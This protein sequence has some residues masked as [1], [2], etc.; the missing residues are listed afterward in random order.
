M[1]DEAPI[2]PARNVELSASGRIPDLTNSCRSPAQLNQNAW[3]YIVGA[4]RPRRPCA[5][6]AC[7]STRSHVPPARVLRNVAEVDPSAELFGLQIAAAG[8]DR[9]LSARLRYF[10]SRPALLLR[11][12]AGNV[13]RRPC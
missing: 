7:R 13:R 1:N 3:D 6:T 2:Q 12:R 10:I 5:A 9:T 8:D 11:A 4:S